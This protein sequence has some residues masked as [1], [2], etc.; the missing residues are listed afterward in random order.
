MTEEIAGRLR[1][2]GHTVGAVHRD[3]GRE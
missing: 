2:L 3:L 1:E